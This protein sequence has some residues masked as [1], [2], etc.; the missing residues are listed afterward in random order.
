MCSPALQDLQL[1]QGWKITLCSVERCWTPTSHKPP[2]EVSPLPDSQHCRPSQLCTAEPSTRPRFGRPASARHSMARLVP[3][4]QAHHVPVLPGIGKSNPQGFGA[5][6]TQPEALP[7]PCSVLSHREEPLPVHTAG[8]GTT[9][10]PIC[11][12]SQPHSSTGHIPVGPCSGVG[13]GTCRAPPTCRP[14]R[15]SCSSMAL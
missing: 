2:P 7:P 12:S 9:S 8:T 6:G 1:Q 10:C 3:P 15:G 11:P 5:A 14:E 13:L 4:V